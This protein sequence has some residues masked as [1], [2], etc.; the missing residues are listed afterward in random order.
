MKIALDTNILVQDFWFDS[1]HSK[2]FLEELN[3]IPAT[4]HIPEV[5]VDETVNK[6]KE[7]LNEKAAERKKINADVSRLL[8]KSLPEIAI[9]FDQAGKDYE[10]FLK[11]KLQEVNAQI[12]QY[13]K[14]D[15]KDVV[16]HI[17]DRRRPF[18]KGDAGYRDFLIWQTIKRLE[19]WGTEEIVFITN[20]TK[21]FGES[22][23]ISEEFTDKTTKN[24][25]FKISV[26][27]SKFND[28]YILPR[29]RKLDELKLQLL[30]GQV[31]SFDFKK[32]LD[33]EFTEFIK[34][35]DLEEVLA[36]FP[37]GVG[38]VKASE[39][40][41]YDDYKIGDV[42]Q[43][44]SGEKLVQFSVKCKIDAHVDI[45]WQ[46]YIN[47]EEV[48]KY[49]SDSTEEFSYIT[50]MTSGKI[51]VEG[52]LILDKHN[53]EVNEFEITLLEGPE[54]SIEMGI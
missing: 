46:D 29:L 34:E 4:L 14:V 10:I 33:N 42:S 13:P 54:G 11:Q 25:N 3:I 48:R 2:V 51:E 19:A 40:L 8:K 41:F 39:I 50:G 1:P 24:K 27:V 45:T 18:K 28:E 38:R 26:A 32:W 37:N 53:E 20:N 21:D 12:L 15:H 22:G 31:Q 35:V 30:K 36:G 17:L 43:L 5:V 23:F 16:K 44:H 47:H 9:D 52:Y 49:Y 6:Y 7:F